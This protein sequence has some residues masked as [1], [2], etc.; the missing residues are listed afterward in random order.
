LR[1]Q[2]KEN[3]GAGSSSR[4][5]E[6]LPPSGPEVERKEVREDFWQKTSEPRTS[7]KKIRRESG[8][9][10]RLLIA[11]KDA[12]GGPCVVQI[13]NGG[14]GTDGRGKKNWSKAV[15]SVVCD[16]GKRTWPAS[17]KKTKKPTQRRFPLLL[18]TQWPRKRTKNAVQGTSD[19]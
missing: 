13:K 19:L 6:S 18:T 12:A 15:A 8:G 11:A 4:P 2:R 10:H 5:T 17:K 9:V 7:E 1:E 14:R 16:H 3:E